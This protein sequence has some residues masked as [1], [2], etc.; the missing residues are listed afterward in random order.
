MVDNY[1]N[2][3]TAMYTKKTRKVRKVFNINDKKAS[4]PLRQSIAFFAVKCFLLK[5]KILYILK[6]TD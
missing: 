6:H 3:L 4:C 5:I 2:I 1:N